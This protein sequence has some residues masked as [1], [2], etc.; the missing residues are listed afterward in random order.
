MTDVP[1]SH[2]PPC[3]VCGHPWHHFLACSDTCDC[4][5]QPIPGIDLL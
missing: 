3:H 2:D 4:A 1:L 5:S